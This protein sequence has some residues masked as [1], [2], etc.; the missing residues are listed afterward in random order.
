MSCISLGPTYKFCA[1]VNSVNSWSM[2][3]FGRTIPQKSRGSIIYD[4]VVLWDAHEVFSFLST[5]KYKI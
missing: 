4:V 5:I 1:K 3:K 2:Q